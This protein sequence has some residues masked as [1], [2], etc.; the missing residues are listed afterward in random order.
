MSYGILYLEVLPTLSFR[1]RKSCNIDIGLQLSA[2]FND[3]DSAY[4]QITKVFDSKFVKPGAWSYYTGDIEIAKTTFKE[5][6]TIISK[7]KK[8]GNNALLAAF[9]GHVNC[10]KHAFNNDDGHVFVIAKYMGHNH[11]LELFV[12]FYVSI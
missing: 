11:I 3:I 4:T 6:A 9:H 2:T 12:P 5:Q 8:C 10:L 7:C 1:I